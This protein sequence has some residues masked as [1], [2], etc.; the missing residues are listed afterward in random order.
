MALYL[1]LNRGELLSSPDAAPLSERL[2]LN[3]NREIWDPAPGRRLLTLR[4]RTAD[5]QGALEHAL[6]CLVWQERLWRSCH[7]LSTFYLF[8]YLIM[9]P[10]RLDR[11]STPALGVPMLSL[12]I[13][14]PSLR[15]RVF[16]STLS[17]TTYNARLIHI[18][19][20]RVFK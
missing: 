8:T 20:L 9:T 11:L 18:S 3:A 19:S 17:H 16:Y 10:D 13:T 4:P 12:R 6:S 14:C 1:T 2:E 7:D 5:E 15:Y